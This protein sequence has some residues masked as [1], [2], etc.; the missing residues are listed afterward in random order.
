ME[1]V[2]TLTGTTVGK[3]A[4]VAVTGLVLFG[5]VIAHMLGNLQAFLGPEVFNH[6]AE[7]LRGLPALVWTERVVVGSSVVIHTWLVLDLYTRSHAAR[8]VAYRRQDKLVTSYAAATMKYSGPALLLYILFHIAHFTAPGSGWGEYEHSATDVYGNF[9]NAFTVP[10]IAA[11][12]VVANSL[13]GMHLYHGI[14]SLFQTLG[15]N[16]SRYSAGIKQGAQA[17][18]LLITFGN[19][20]MPLAVQAGIIQLP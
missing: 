7:T 12:Y 18:A 1:K 11:I 3:K 9:V 6:Y 8:P 17:I 10:W 4:A 13:L 14:W 19:V 5:F 2:L 20:S 16:H 15:L